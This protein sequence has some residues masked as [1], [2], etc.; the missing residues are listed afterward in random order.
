[1]GL[2]NMA[3]PTANF[4]SYNSTGIATEKCEFINNIC[5]END[6]QF[7]SIQEHFKNHKTT[8]KYFCRKFSQYNSYVI[9]G[10]RPKEQDSGR[11][12]AGLAQLTRKGL[13]VKKDRISTNSYRIQAQNLILY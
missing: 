13:D 1:M 11:P 9:P 2:A 8:D 10:F 4:L 3:T 12:K 5:K 6:I 7:V